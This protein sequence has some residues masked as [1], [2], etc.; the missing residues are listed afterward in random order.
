MT[1]EIKN[2]IKSY[3]IDDLGLEEDLPDDIELFSSK[4]LD[5]IDVLKLIQFLES[6]FNVKFNPLDVSLDTFDTP[7]KIT[8]AVEIRVK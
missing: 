3:L 8:N 5:S 6:S 4:T 2:K 7:N 1:T